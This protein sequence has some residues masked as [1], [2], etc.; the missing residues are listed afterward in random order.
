MYSDVYV[1]TVAGAVDVTKIGIFST[2]DA[3]TFIATGLN[4]WATTKQAGGAQQDIS[5]TTPAASGTLS[6]L[7]GGF[8]ADFTALASWTRSAIAMQAAWNNSAVTYTGNVQYRF[9]FPYS[10]WF[11]PTVGVSYAELYN[12]NFQHKVSDGTEVH[13]GMRFGTEMTWM[14]FTVQPTLSGTVF[15]VVGQSGLVT[16]ELVDQHWVVVNPAGAF[17]FRGSA[18]MTVLWTPSFSSYLDIHGSTISNPTT[19]GN[20]IFGVQ[21]GLRYTF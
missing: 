13:G 19:V 10:V 7:N 4:S 6:Y 18:K 8:S 11:E 20:Q 1:T 16:S 21:G 3:L 2:T 17:G 9:D 5:S 15:K 14:G 12:G